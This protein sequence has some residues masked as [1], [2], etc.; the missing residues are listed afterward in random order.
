MKLLLA[1][2][3]SAM[4]GETVDQLARQNFATDSYHFGS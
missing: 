2:S 1:I 4:S 3:G